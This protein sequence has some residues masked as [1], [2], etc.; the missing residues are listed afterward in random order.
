MKITTQNKY[1]NIDQSSK[2]IETK[3]NINTET[4]ITEEF[5]KEVLNW[6]KKIKEKINKDLENDREKNIMMSEKQWHALMNK[7]D[8]A[9][10]THNQYIKENAK[11]A[12]S[13][14]NDEDE[15]LYDDSYAGFLNNKKNP[16]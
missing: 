2:K 14:S 1:Y 13:K 3:D 9:I 5:K 4:N 15:Q 12:Y 7:V 6:G 16:N 10:N 8:S 11:I